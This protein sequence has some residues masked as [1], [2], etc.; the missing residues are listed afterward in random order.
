MM[1][2]VLIAAVVALG[3]MGLAAV[4]EA[5]PCQFGSSPIPYGSYSVCLTSYN[6]G[7]YGYWSAS[8]YNY[9]STSPVFEY[10]SVYAGQS[11]FNYPGCCNGGSTNAGMGTGTNVPYG[12]AYAGAYNYK[13]NSCC[14]FSFAG[15]GAYAG[16][17][18]AG[19]SAGQYS[20]P[21]YCQ[22]YV[23]A[24]FGTSQP[25]GPVPVLPSVPY[26]PVPL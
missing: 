13:Y 7:N 4:A 6:S 23:Y 3:A 8:A 1:K 18:P 25:C 14:G 11:Q 15:T 19:V 24:F 9:Q 2:K 16:A 20:G 5:V 26:V 12:Y 10:S 21:G 22:M 17:G